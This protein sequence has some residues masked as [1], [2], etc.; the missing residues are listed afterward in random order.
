MFNTDA[1]AA[2]LRVLRESG[3]AMVKADIIG[4]LEAGG[5][6]RAA[7]ES[8]WRSVQRRLR[9]D[10]RII[11][12]KDGHS[13]R[14]CWNPDA[15]PTALDALALLVK[16]KL[17]SA[18]RES[19]AETIRAALAATP[20]PPK[21]RAPKE[22]T[23]SVDRL[24]RVERD[25]VMALVEMAMDVE[26][27]VAKGASDTAIIHLVRSRMRRLRLNAVEKAGERVFFDPRRHDPMRPGIPDGAP[28][29]VVR[30]G[31][32]WESPYGTEVLVRPLVQ[33]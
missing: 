24:R 5:V 25:A 31:Y 8:A 16:G 22:Q 29:L 14:Y 2:V 6:S 4:G 17:T 3:R 12:K 20:R 9:T 1:A 15:P 28:V 27:N 32:V 21:P 10:E 33:D 11:V 18:E 23:V 30:P 7:A 19:L 26:E 13:T